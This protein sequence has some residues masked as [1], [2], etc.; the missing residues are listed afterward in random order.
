MISLVV[1][2]QTLTDLNTLHRFTKGTVYSMPIDR[3]EEWSLGL[4]VL[5]VINMN[6]HHHLALIPPS[7][8]SS[9]LQG[10]IWCGPTNVL[11][12]PQNACY[13]LLVQEWS[14]PLCILGLPIL[15]WK[16]PGYLG[17]EPGRDLGRV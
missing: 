14:E 7:T 8:G 6:E 1:C 12:P 5:T 3:V 17:V 4:S 9:S 11:V 13:Y 10:G 2:V 15:G 16:N